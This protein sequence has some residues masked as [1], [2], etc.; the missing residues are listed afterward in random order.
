MDNMKISLISMGA[1]C[2]VCLCLISSAEESKWEASELGQTGIFQMDN[3]PYPDESR[4]EG[5]KIKDR[6]YPREPH[7]I[8][9]SVA[10][11]IP[12]GYRPSKKIDL[13]YYFHGHGNN[14][15]GSLEQF[16]LRQQVMTS[17]KNVILV[18]PQGPKDAGDSGGGKMESAGG[19]K[20]LTEE[21]L[22]VL[23]DEGKIDAEARLGKIVLSGHSGAYRVI[24]F[25]VEHGGLED[26][27]SEVYLLDSS[28]ARLDQFVDW[29]ARNRRARLLSVFTD[30][31]A[32]E[33]VY[34]MTHMARAG[35]RYRLMVDEDAT[36]RI[37]ERNR[38]VFLHTEKLK[39]NETVQWLARWL[40]TSRLRER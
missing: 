2:V 21:V 15:R 37:L 18:F 25:C 4:S 38:V 9:N 16:Q 26:H 24:S 32:D 11:F 13:L 22:Q 30:H 10:L 14:I 28:Y 8:D 40:R 6:F 35:V 36:D 5:F 31:L 23:R 34:L 17:D 12:R 1:F 3:A 29:V 33:N 20:R 7:Y 19:L 27:L 39:H